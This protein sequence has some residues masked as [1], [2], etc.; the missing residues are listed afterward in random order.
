M[1][2]VVGGNSDNYFQ[3]LVCEKCCLRLVALIGLSVR[4]AESM[5]S[6]KH[7]MRQWCPCKD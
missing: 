3:L 2:D 1:G 6:R 4:R 5:T 7:Q